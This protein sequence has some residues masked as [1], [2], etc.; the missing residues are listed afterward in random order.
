MADFQEILNNTSSK[1]DG[2]S[3]DEVKTNLKQLEVL[4]NDTIDKV[5]SFGAENKDKRSKITTLEAKLRDFEQSNDESTSSYEKLKTSNS[6]LLEEV[7]DLRQFKSN[8][9]SAQKKDLGSKLNELMEHPYFDKAKKFLHIPDVD[10]EG[11]VDWDSLDESQVENNQKELSRLEDLDYF[12][13]QPK[14]K[15]VDGSLK[16]TAP[17]SVTHEIESATTIEALQEIQSRFNK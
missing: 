3:A 11:N 13:N 4:Y 9:Y 6:S 17:N 8:T 2:E 10:K 14:K 16:A 12:N 5:K 7:E 1:V 15:E